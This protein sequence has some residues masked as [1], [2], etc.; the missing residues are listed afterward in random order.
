M[1]GT[2]LYGLPLFLLLFKIAFASL[3][4]ACQIERYEEKLSRSTLLQFLALLTFSYFLLCLGNKEG[5]QRFSDLCHHE[6]ERERDRVTGRGVDFP[7]LV[8]LVCK[9]LTTLTLHVTLE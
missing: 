3:L 4:I 8:C 1:D 5:V 7:Y 6:R 2:P 9:G